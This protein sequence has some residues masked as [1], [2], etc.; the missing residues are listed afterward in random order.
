MASLCHY[1]PFVSYFAIFRRQARQTMAATIARHL[2]SQCLKL[3]RSGPCFVMRQCCSSA[4]LQGC[5]LSGRSGHS[6]WW[7][8]TCYQSRLPRQSRYIWRLESSRSS[9][10]C[11]GASCQWLSTFHLKSSALAIDP[12]VWVS[13]SGRWSQREALRK[14]G[15]SSRLVHPQSSYLAW[16]PRNGATLARPHL[17]CNLACGDRAIPDS[18]GSSIPQLSHWT[19]AYAW[20]LTC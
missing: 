12:R 11:D 9:L 15:P 6:C 18:Q 7:T 10:Y 16:A 20:S 19:E 17:H 8:K 1:R 13:T 2:E 3:R 5:L 4:L 14:M